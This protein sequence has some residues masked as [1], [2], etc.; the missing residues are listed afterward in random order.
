[1]NPQGRLVILSGPS[2]VGKDTVLEAWTKSNPRV[3][4]VVAYTTRSPRAGE[5]DGVDYHFV[6]RQRFDELVEENA[7][8][9]HKLVHGNCY[10]TPLADMQSML[11]AGKVAVLKIDVQGALEVMKLRND[12]LSIFLMPPSVEELEKR[13][14]T[15]GTDSSEVIE[16][17][18][19]SARDEIACAEQYTARVVNDDI[20]R[21]VRELNDLV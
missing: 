14:R 11:L 6:T 10:A 1:M 13:I 12:A 9:E 21:V 17:R 4:R 8:L 3:Q 5:N 15:R 19:Q 2:G 16:Q 7:F 20:A 18:L